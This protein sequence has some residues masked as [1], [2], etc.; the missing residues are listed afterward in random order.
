MEWKADPRP[1]PR[2]RNSLIGCP[3]SEGLWGLGSWS[4]STGPSWTLQ[5]GGPE[6]GLPT[7]LSTFDICWFWYRSVHT[8]CFCSS[9]KRSVVI[10][11]A[12][13]KVWALT[14]KFYSSAWLSPITVI[15]ILQFA[16]PVLTRPFGLGS[17]TILWCLISEESFILILSVC[18][19]GDTSWR[20]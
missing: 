8:S 13:A 7:P 4:W 2:D 12:C 17:S 19:Y 20:Y 10:K 15:T 3:T 11:E 16:E 1:K 9:Y 5:L 6:L 14:N 18:K